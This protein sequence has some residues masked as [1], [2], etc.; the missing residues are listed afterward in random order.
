MS[1]K[2]VIE[3]GVFTGAGQKALAFGGWNIGPDAIIG[4]P[5]GNLRGLNDAGI[6]LALSVEVLR[7]KR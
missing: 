6:P 7:R 4:V 3:S 2:N 1:K 5:G